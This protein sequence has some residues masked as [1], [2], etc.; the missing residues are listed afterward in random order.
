M[1]GADVLVRVTKIVL[2]IVMFEL[3]H[4]SFDAMN[5]LPAAATSVWT[6]Q[7]GVA[8][9]GVPILFLLVGLVLVFYQFVRIA[10]W[11]MTGAPTREQAAEARALRKAPR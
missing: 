4:M 1:N 5:A 7:Q 8:A 10:Y 6:T 3:G 2:G 11:L 9:L